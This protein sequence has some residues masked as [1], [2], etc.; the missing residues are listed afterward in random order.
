MQEQRRMEKK[1]L[2]KFA[3]KIEAGKEPNGKG[4][5]DGA[6]K[7]KGS[8][9]KN[10]KSEPKKKPFDDGIKDVSDDVDQQVFGCYVLKFYFIPWNFYK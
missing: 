2:E 6:M 4:I 3:D 7:K 5:S 8:A 9:Q 10:K 1:Q